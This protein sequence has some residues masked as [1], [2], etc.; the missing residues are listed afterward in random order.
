MKSNNTACLSCH[1]SRLCFVPATSLSENSLIS[2]K[3]VGGAACKEAAHTHCTRRLRSRFMLVPL[4]QCMPLEKIP[5]H[6]V[7]VQLVGSLAGKL[8][9]E[10]AFAARPMMAKSFDGVNQELAPV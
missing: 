3:E 6:V 4:R 10:L 8:F 1:S 5:D 9:F 7:R 2:P